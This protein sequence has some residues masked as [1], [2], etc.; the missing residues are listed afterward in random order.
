MNLDGKVFLVTG[1]GRGVGAAIALRAA[2]AGARVALCGRNTQ[3]LDE[4][5]DGVRAAGGD[6]MT[7]V[8][9][10]L[11]P[12][13]GQRLVEAVL[14]RFG[15]LDVLVNNAGIHSN[16]SVFDLTE[17]EWDSVLD[18]NLKAVF[19]CSQAAARVMRERG[20]VIVNIASVVGV[21]GFPNRAAYAASKGGVVQL[22]RALAAE[23]A[24]LG[25]RVNSVASSVIRTAM[26]EP[27]LNDPNYAAEVKRRTPLGRPG[28]PD[29]VANAVLY[30]ASPG[31]GYVTGH[32]MMID[33]GW[34]AI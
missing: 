23:L 32:T 20:G 34:S 33:G 17:E 16:R 5:A 30:L 15:A 25:I 1:A 18:T 29:D 3:A 6:V 2:E 9:D 8:Q 22:T 12:G 21:V 28:T 13:A 27:L 14:A 24:P 7:I 10:L 19:F 11:A 26:T 31:A 4:V